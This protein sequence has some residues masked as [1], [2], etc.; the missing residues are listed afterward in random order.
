MRI[1][2]SAILAL[3]I[4]GTGDANATEVYRWTDEKG[5]TQYSDTPP[6]RGA[7]ERV[8]VRTGK[9]AEPAPATNETAGSDVAATAPSTTQVDPAVRAE[10]CRNA[11]SNLFALRSGLDVTLEKD[12]ESRLL[13][14]EERTVQIEQNEKVVTA[15]CDGE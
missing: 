4:C 9:I 12:G 13:T 10:R 6:G 3:A 7:Y 8:N 5:V 1:L 11:R 2:S 15:N 14:A